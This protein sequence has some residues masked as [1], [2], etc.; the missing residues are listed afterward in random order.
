M[1]LTPRDH[2]LLLDL[3]DNGAALAED[4]RRWFP[5]PAAARVRLLQLVRAGY[6]EVVE[7]HRRRRLY[8]LGRAGKRCYGIHS[9]WRTRLQE[10]LRQAIWRRCHVQLVGEGYG[11]MG[12]L[13]GGLVLYRSTAGPSLAVQVFTV[14]PTARHL[15]SLLRR[16][17]VSLVREGAVLCVFGPQTSRLQR[18]T[19]D[20]SSVSLR[21][22][23]GDSVQ[24]L[25]RAGST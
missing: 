5:S 17:R 7:H 23:P 11:R 12:S 4:L 6:I 8:A 13:H 18:S 14:G 1:R 9:N 10:A 20:S 2:Q 25:G 3:R 22:L 19:G 21:T 16:H 15:R 24:I